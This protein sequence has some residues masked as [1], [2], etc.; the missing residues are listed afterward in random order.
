MTK[1]YYFKN[2]LIG[3]IWAAIFIFVWFDDKEKIIFIS[4]FSLSSAILFP[5]SRLFLEKILSR[6]ISERFKDNRSTKN[7]SAENGLFAVFYTIT[8]VL[9]LPIVLISLICKTVKSSR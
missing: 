7:T 8:F 6:L 3:F 9:T 4:V 2:V 5:F 1:S